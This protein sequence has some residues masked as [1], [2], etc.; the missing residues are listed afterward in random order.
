VA[1]APEYDPP[2]QGVATLAMHADPAGQEE[3]EGE[4]S[5]G[6]YWPEEQLQLVHVIA[7]GEGDAVPAGQKRAMASP[8]Q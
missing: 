3:H 6:Q 5:E 1:E 4:S 2:G 7:P 8:E